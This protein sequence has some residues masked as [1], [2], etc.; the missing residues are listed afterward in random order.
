MNDPDLVPLEKQLNGFED[1]V[2]RDFGG[3]ERT[4]S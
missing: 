2:E 3:G 1:N 4:S